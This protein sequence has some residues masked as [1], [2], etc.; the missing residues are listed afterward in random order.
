M[1][2]GPF[3]LWT[4]IVFLVGAGTVLFKTLYVACAG[5]ARLTA[6]FLSLA[7]FVHYPEER[8]RARFIRGFCVFYPIL[9]LVLF[10]LF[11]EPRSMVIFGGTAQAAT[12]PI[13][14]GL[15]VYFRYRGTDRRLAPSLISDIL[16]WVAFVLISAVAVYYLGT[17][18]IGLLGTKA[19]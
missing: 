10:L 8:R 4:Q 9:A 6:D 14:S 17:Q 2:V 13:I 7:K 1:F 5:H 16:L 18:F 12:L 19:S 11:G 3:G 15:T